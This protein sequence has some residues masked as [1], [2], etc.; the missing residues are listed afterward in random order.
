VQEHGA[1]VF[2][3]AYLPTSSWLLAVVVVEDLVVGAVRVDIEHQQEPLVGV[4]LLNLH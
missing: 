4:R 2:L 1:G 3:W